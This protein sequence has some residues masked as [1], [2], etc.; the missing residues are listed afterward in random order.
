MSTKPEKPQ[1]EADPRFPSGPWT[2]FWI[3]RGAGKQKMQVGFT[4]I[5]GGVSGEGRDV[6]GRFTFAGTYDLKTG[7]CV[8]AKQ[9]LG[10]HRV[11]YDGVNEGE[12]MWLWGLWAVGGDKGGFHLWPEGEP[13]PT[14]KRTAAELELPVDTREQRQRVPADLLPF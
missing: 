9:Y 7:R 3:Q 5:D 8:L 1:P 12:G 13:D 10:A 14:Q 2:G 11:D 4:F 6:I